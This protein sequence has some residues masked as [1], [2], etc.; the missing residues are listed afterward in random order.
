MGSEAAGDE[1]EQERPETRL[2]FLVH[3]L[4]RAPGSEGFVQLGSGCGS[5]GTVLH[6]PLHGKL[7]ELTAQD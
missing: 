4:C 1:P 6:V 3:F 7:Q 2:H 5:T